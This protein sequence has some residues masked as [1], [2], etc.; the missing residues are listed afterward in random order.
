VQFASDVAVDGHVRRA[1]RNFSSMT[2]LLHCFK[3]AAHRCWHLIPVHI[4]H[5]SLHLGVS[6]RMPFGTGD[7]T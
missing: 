4:C 1:S 6:R 7:L 3:Y 2:A 5:E